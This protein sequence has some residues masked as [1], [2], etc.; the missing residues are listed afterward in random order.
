MDLNALIADFHAELAA[1]GPRGR[2]V[3]YPTDFIADTGALV[4]LLREHG[5]TRKAIA[6]TLGIRWPTL[7]RWSSAGASSETPAFAPVEIVQSHAPRDAA[8]TG[9]TLVS[10]SGWR[11]EGLD[12]ERALDLLARLA[13]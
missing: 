5:W 10:P 2:G 8:P 13:C 7:H 9:V 1:L 4:V 12:P 11:L 6:H 3:R